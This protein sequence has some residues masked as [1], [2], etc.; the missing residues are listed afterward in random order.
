M[1]ETGETIEEN[2]VSH[3]FSHAQILLLSEPGRR[4]H[5]LTELQLR[6][7]RVPV[8]YPLHV[9]VEGRGPVRRPFAQTLFL[10]L[11]YLYRILLPAP[12]PY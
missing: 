9:R 4:T 7:L 12:E 11:C 3:T 1:R 2:G 5:L 8:G 10:C 6:P